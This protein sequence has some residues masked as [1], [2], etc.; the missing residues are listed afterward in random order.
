MEVTI[1]D[2]VPA[3]LFQEYCQQ[4]QCDAQMKDNGSSCWEK[5]AFDESKSSNNHLFVRNLQVQDDTATK[6]VSIGRSHCYVNGQ[7]IFKDFW[8]DLS[9]SPLTNEDISEGEATNQFWRPIV[10]ASISAR[11]KVWNN[12]LF[13]TDIKFRERVCQ[14]TSLAFGNE[15]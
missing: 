12:D 8:P 3:K 9:T 10:G 5:H 6:T 4:P 14:P 1:A 13:L 2:V 11:L 15:D 7:N